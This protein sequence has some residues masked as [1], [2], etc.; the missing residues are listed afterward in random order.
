MN[1]IGLIPIKG[2][3]TTF[4][5]KNLL[6]ESIKY[7]KS[8]ELISDIYVSTDNSETAELA[9]NNGGL[10]PFIRPIELSDESVSL[11]DVLKYTIEEIE[12]IRK[13]D[14]VVIVEENYPFRP[15]G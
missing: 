4:E 15:E 3:P 6:I 1:I 12:K 14:L 9:I 2:L 11:P 7:L 8:C 10:A 5:G 13:V